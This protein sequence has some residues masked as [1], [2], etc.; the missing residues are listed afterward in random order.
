M[1][2]IDECLPHEPKMQTYSVTVGNGEDAETVEM[3]AKNILEVLQRIIGDPR[4]REDI[5][6]VPQRHYVD[7]ARKIRL[8]GQTYAGNYMWRMQVSIQETYRIVLI[9]YQVH[10]PNQRRI[11]YSDYRNTDVG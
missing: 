11:R 9:S 5:Q 10:N 3:C 4:F 1:K 6:Y 2:D 7:E 8:H